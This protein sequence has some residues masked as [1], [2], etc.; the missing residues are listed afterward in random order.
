MKPYHKV[1]NL[2]YYEMKLGTETICPLSFL[3]TSVE[4][5][6]GATQSVLPA[7][8]LADN[9]NADTMYTTPCFGSG[10]STMSPYYNFITGIPFTSPSSTWVVAT[11]A[12]IPLG[13]NTV[14]SLIT[15]S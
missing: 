5:V 8:L 14:P 1:L 2:L 15:I 4:D 6:L 10:K 11:L 12:T 13:G 9:T 7:A 3:I